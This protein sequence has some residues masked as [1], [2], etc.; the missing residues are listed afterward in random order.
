MLNKINLIIEFAK[1]DL[2]ERY[3]GTS[4]GRVWMLIS[5]LTTIFIYTVIFSDFMKMRMNIISSQYA[6]SIYLIPGL[7]SFNYFSVVV[8]RLSTIILDKSHIIKK[9]N[10]CV[11]NMF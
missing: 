1:R 11:R 2:K 10:N 8:S 9:I 3:A 4:F 5:P 7:L 6:Y